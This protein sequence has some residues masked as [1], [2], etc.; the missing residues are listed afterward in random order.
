[1]Y[2]ANSSIAEYVIV[3]VLGSN[4]EYSIVKADDQYGLKVYD[5]IVSDAKSVEEDESVN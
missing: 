3:D 2:V 1:V 5:K 4:S